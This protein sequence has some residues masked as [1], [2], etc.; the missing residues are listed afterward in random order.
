MISTVDLCKDYGSVKALDNISFSVGRGRIMSIMGPSGSGKTTLI[1]LIAGLDQST[2]GRISIGGTDIT[3]FD[4]DEK[5]RFRLEHLGIIFQ[6]FHLVDYLT[7]LDNVMLAQYFHS[8]PDRE[9]A[10]QSLKMVGLG[11]RA[12]HLPGELSGGEKQRVAIARAI[13]N[14]PELILADEPTGNLDEDNERMVMDIFKELKVEGKTIILVTHNHSLGEQ[15]DEVIRLK[16]GRVDNHRI[17]EL[18]MVK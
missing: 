14:D 7:A 11:D 13:T 15:C 3:D 18:E 4:N 2:S 5:A 17:R 16:H 8:M 12:D 6:Q 1:N 10:M 9:D